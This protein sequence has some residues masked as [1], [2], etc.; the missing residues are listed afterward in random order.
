MIRILSVLLL[1]ALAASCAHTATGPDPAP[2]TL[3]ADSLRGT[4]HFAYTQKGPGMFGMM[5]PPPQFDAYTFI[6]PD[7]IAIQST[8]SNWHFTGTYTLAG[9]SLTYR[10]KP[11]DVAKPVEHSVHIAL[12][13]NGESLLVS[14]NDMELVYYRPGRFYPNDIAGHWQIQKD[15]ITETLHLTADGRYELEKSNIVGHYRLWP[16]RYGRAMTAIVEIPGEG[17]FMLLWQYEKSKDGLTM[18]PISTQGLKTSAT[19]TWKLIKDAN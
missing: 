14:F 3:T 12:A 18:T 8:L 6:A 2:A 4:W 5:P 15:G 7:K 13:D 19:I 11:L 1:C 9:T 17:G 16:S 10:F